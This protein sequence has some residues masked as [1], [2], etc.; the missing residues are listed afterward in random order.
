[1]PEMRHIDYGLGLFRREAFAPY[2]PHEVLDLATVQTS[3]AS[4]GQLAGFE[5]TQRF[6]E[7]GSH[8]GLNEL[9]ALLRRGHFPADS[10]QA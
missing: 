9:D 6:F 3:L 7:I 1:M 2:S 4:E 10:P 5:V 8:A